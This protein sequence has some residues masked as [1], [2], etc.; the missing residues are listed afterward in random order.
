MK[1]I[2]VLVLLLFA[3]LMC[4]SS[5]AFTIKAITVVG[6]QRIP[7]DTVLNYIPVKVGDDLGPSNTGAVISALY[8]TGF[9]DKITLGREGNTL[10]IHLSERPTIGRLKISGNVTIKSEQLTSVLK[11]VGIEQGRAYDNVILEKIRQSLLDQYYLLGRYNAHVIV[12]ATPMDR[13]RMLV[14]IDISEGLVAKVKRI[15]IIGNHAF[16]DKTLIKQLDVATTGLFSYFTKTDR[17][18]QEKLDASLDKL[19]NYYMDR[20]YLRFAVKS[21]QVAMTPDHK[22]IFITIVID[23]GQ[24]Y[25]V[26]AIHFQGRTIL[27]SKELAEKNTL[28]VGDIFSRKAVM[29]TEKAINDALGDQGYINAE[30]NLHPTFDETHHEVI[31]T[32]LIKQGRRMYVRH[33]TFIDNV[34]TNDNVLRRES[35][36]LEGAPVSSGRIEDSKGR[37][38]RLPFIKNVDTSITPVPGSNNQVDVHYKVKEDNAAQASLSVSYGR[39]TGVGFGVGLNQKNFLGTGETLGI[40]ATRNRYEQVFGIDFTNPYY[41]EDGISRSI[42][43]SASKF[44]PHL[45]NA[46]N[47]YNDNEYS[48]SVLYGIPV[49]Q[50]TSVSQRVQLGYGYDQTQLHLVAP[51]IQVLSFVKQHGR[52]F[53]QLELTAG[54]SLDSRDHAI[55][56]TKGGLQTIGATLYLPLSGQSLKYYILNWSGSW[57]QPIAGQFI[58]LARGNL[59]F[60]NSFSGGDGFPFFRNFYAGGIGSVR[61]YT[62]NTLGPTD[63]TTD[64]YGNRNHT[65]GNALATG[66]LGLIFPNFVSD[67]LR[68]VAFIDAGNVYN[69]W[70]NKKYQGGGSGPL[71]YGTGL[72]IDWLSPMGPIEVSATKA[73]NPRSG[74]DTQFFDFSL[75]ANFG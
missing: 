46:T 34:K 61:G 32:Y 71:R 9:F 50:S 11:S 4:S 5:W 18:S 66:T 25:R 75:G 3:G 44:Y 37:M 16:D 69:T 47:S 41:T 15:N 19:R 27:S 20:G 10:V 8:Q 2:I 23:E 57:Y 7:T 22:S 21:S 68:T 12:R 55:F 70:N 63:N 13:N 49:G 17:F 54:Y 53:H 59:G 28:H 36:Q 30:I 40:N 60:G 14:K 56:P 45:A 52:Q 62:G 64:G 51:S 33:I 48:L 43:L 29:D 58:G 1:K 65:G 74:D 24:V 39:L 72:E 35:L 26:K 31:L 38:S 6:N 67:S 42:S 73:L